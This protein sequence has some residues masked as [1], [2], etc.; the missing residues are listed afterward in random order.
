MERNISLYDT[1]NAKFMTLEQVGETFVSHSTF[2]KLAKNKHSLILGPR[3]SGKTTFMK[4]LTLPALKK[5]DTREDKFLAIK[6]GLNFISIYIPADLIWEKETKEISRLI[7][8]YPAF[9]SKTLSAIFN[10]SILSNFTRTVQDFFQVKNATNDYARAAPIVERMIREWG[11][12]T[13]LDRDFKSV[14]AELGSW[15]NLIH[16]SCSALEYSNLK[17]HEIERPHFYHLDYLKC[18]EPVCI[19]FD[20]TWELSNDSKWALCFDELEI[21]PEEIVKDLFTELRNPPARFLYKLSTC[22]IPNLTPTIEYGANQMDEYDVIKMWPK[23]ISNKETYDTQEDSEGYQNFCYKLALF[24]FKS[25]LSKKYNYPNEEIDSL[26]LEDFLGNF[27]YWNVLQ[28]Y[29]SSLDGKKL[30]VHKNQRHLDNGPT[31]DDFK[32]NELGW[33]AFR[34]LAEWDSDFKIYL[35]DNG[36]NPNDPKPITMKIRTQIHR[37]LKQVVF[38]R[39]IFTYRNNKQPRYNIPRGDIQFK[40]I[41]NIPFYHGV[42]TLINIVDGNPRYLLGVVDELI[43]ELMSPTNGNSIGRKFKAIGALRQNEIIAKVSDKFYS[44][45]SSIPVKLAV[46]PAFTKH[47]LYNKHLS[48]LVTEIGKTISHQINIAQIKGEPYGS[49][50]IDSTAQKDPN[51]V[52][53][54]KI[55]INW[56]A[57]ILVTDDEKENYSEVAGKRIRLAYLLAPKFKLPLRLYNSFPLTDCLHLNET[58]TAPQQSVLNFNELNGN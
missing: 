51:L 19:I 48:F 37:K 2:A 18:L 55:G 15:L 34:E 56:G 10:I 32:R 5:W 7:G 33:L 40:R 3:G 26:R 27:D 22:P 41:K 47:K 53:L 35:I 9:L 50:T 20:K 28:G 39:L 17:D 25:Q 29:I 4:M 8:R 23:A 1:N 12:S 44:K 58:I 24:R 30:G 13:S 6:E 45:I 46:T 49:I 11:L 14:L 36:I 54:I 42:K 52:D 38:N 31:K 57:F 16:K 21:V 43:D